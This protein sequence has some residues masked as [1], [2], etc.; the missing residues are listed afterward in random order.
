MVEVWFCSIV[1]TEREKLCF[2]QFLICMIL[3]CEVYM[4][5]S[6]YFSFLLMCCTQ[7]KATSITNLLKMLIFVSHKFA[8]Q[9]LYSID[10]TQLVS[11][12]CIIKYSGVPLMLNL[13][14]NNT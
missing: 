11:Y 2:S 1:W 6:Y 13:H 12:F 10:L 8:K 4:C 9:T 5:V 3:V 14:S 7:G